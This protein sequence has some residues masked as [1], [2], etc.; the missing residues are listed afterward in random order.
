[1]ASTTLASP[2]V[3]EA[4]RHCQAITRERARN[5]Y[6]AFLSLPPGQRQ[7][8]YAV[9]AFCRGCDDYADDDI[10][11]QRKVELL[12]GYRA[13]LHQC[14]QGQSSGPVFQALQDAVERYQIPQQYFDDIVTGVEMD[15]TIS[16]YATFQDL[17]TYCYRVASVV[18]LISI[19]VFGYSSPRAKECAVD[20]GIAMQL[21]NIIR[22]IKEDAERDRIYLPQDELQRFGYTEQE[23]FRGVLNQPFSDLMAFQARRARQYFRSGRKL[24]PMVPVRTR[25]CPA[26]L[27]GLY[28]KLLDRIE[29]RRWDV[30]AER[31]RLSTSEKLWLAG[32]TWT[33]TMLRATL[34]AG[35]S[36]S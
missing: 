6:F 26:I 23:L 22:D 14:Y 2:T 4:Y 13:Q 25:P 5:F 21:V 36:S 24:L 35:K 15:L 9:Y 27:S 29:A 7:A 20:M 3:G 31:V 8:V 17:Y 34:P 28:S 1:M 16:R 30:F 18:G 33:G 19:Q 12:E 32:R 10:E 11:L